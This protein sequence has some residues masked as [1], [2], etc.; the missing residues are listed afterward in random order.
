MLE[1]KTTSQILRIQ[2]FI[3]KEI[4][5]QIYKPSS[6]NLIFKTIDWN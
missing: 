1:V 3:T 6:I 4:D 2:L 5:A